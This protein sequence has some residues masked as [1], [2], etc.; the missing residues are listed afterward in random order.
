VPH[1]PADLATFLA[2]EQVTAEEAVLRHAQIIVPM[3]AKT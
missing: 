1:G 3:E 2:E